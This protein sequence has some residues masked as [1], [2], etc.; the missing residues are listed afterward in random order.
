MVIPNSK[1]PPC[2]TPPTSYRA[3]KGEH[4]RRIQLALIQLDSAAIAPDGVYGPAT[5]YKRKRNIVNR[6]YQTQADNIV[7]KM[8]IMSLDKEMLDQERR[9]EDTDYVHCDF[10]ATDRHPS[11]LSSPFLLASTGAAPAPSPRTEALGHKQDAINWIVAAKT[12]L[13]TARSLMPPALAPDLNKLKTNGRM[14]RTC[15]TLQ[16]R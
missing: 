16:V 9:Q 7:G 5:A 8:T 14:G 13:Q 2:P 15:H 3:R 10:G 4:V 12:Y 1:P 6:S 11:I